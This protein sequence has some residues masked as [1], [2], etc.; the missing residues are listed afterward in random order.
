MQRSQL[1]W[2]RLNPRADHH[3]MVQCL[4]PYSATHVYTWLPMCF[5][6][7]HLWGYIIYM[8][9]IHTFFGDIPNDIYPF[10]AARGLQT[11]SANRLEDCKLKFCL[12]QETGQNWT[13]DHQRH[14][15]IWKTDTTTASSWHFWYEHIYILY[16]PAQCCRTLLFNTNSTHWRCTEPYKAAEFCFGRPK[17]T[18]ALARSEGAGVTMA[19]TNNPPTFCRKVHTVFMHVVS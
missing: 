10:N 6:W 5:C 8:Y 3:Y 17:E 2:L 15:K 4:V 16:D 19:G 14:R 11:V 9:L 12:E 18:A 7:T 1:I 13:T